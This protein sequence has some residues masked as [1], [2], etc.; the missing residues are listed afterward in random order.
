M[1]SKRLNTNMCRQAPHPRARQ[2]ITLL[3]LL[4]ILAFVAAVVLI[5]L[6]T[7][8]PTAREASVAFAK[9]QLEYLADRE[10][11][12]FLHYGTYAPFSKL[13]ADEVIGKDFDTR[14]KED[15]V[16]VKGI[17]F[18]GPKTEAKIFDIIAELPDGAR[19]HVDQSGE[20][21]AFK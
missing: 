11:E 6:P 3:E 9:Q 21:R 12:Y 4:I 1:R 10:Q 13:A 18:Q 8:K 17:K 14:F 5:A 19:Y 7:L 2:G 20:I 16:E 15:E